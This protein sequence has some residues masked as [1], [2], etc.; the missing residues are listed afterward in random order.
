MGTGALSAYAG[1]G[2]RRTPK[3]DQRLMMLCSALLCVRGWEL[4]TGGAEGAD[5]AF[6]TGLQFAPARPGP[7][8]KLFLPWPGFNKHN[9]ATLEHPTPE[10]YE[11]AANYHPAWQFL[12]RPVKAL[13]ARNVHQVLGENLDDPVLMVVCWTPDGTLDGKGRDS[14][15]TGMALRVAAGEAPN[16]MIFNIQRP[17]HRERIE[18]FCT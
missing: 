14:G 6:L 11:I 1:I 18:R 10:A 13:L 7:R 5:T 4:R 8:V 15:G 9:Q 17:D 16:A 12:T 2:S 3:A